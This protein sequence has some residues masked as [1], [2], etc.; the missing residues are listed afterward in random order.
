MLKS[1]RELRGFTLIELLVVI[2]I[3]A[4]L[5][6]ILLPALSSAKS[7]AQRLKCLANLRSLGQTS[8]AYSNDDAQGVYGP[9]HRCYCCYGGE[10]Y[11]EYGGGPGT[12]SV[13]GWNDPFGP[14]TR[15]FNKYYYGAAMSQNTA[16][17]DTGHFQS[18]L[19]TGEDYGWQNWPGFGAEPEALEQPYFKAYG[20]SF[21]MNNLSYTDGDIAGVY[22]RPNSRIPD[23]G[24]TVGYMECRAFQTVWSNNT[25]GS[26]THGELKGYHRKLGFFNLLYAD[27][28][29]QTADMGDGTYYQHAPVSQYQGKDVRGSWGKMDCQPDSFYED[30]P[31]NCCAPNCN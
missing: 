8:Q 20:T 21:R 12:V 27:G 11:F 19:C 23:T 25:W 30:G 29:A 17:G 22:G 24:A 28:H 14:N 9:V 13:A 18:F 10:G 6:S 15:P 2:S 31:P 26:A 5:I 16:P 1:K 3:I 7:N 4:V